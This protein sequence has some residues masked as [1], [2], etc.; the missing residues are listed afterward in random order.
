MKRAA[1]LV[2]FLPFLFFFAQLIPCNSFVC[3]GFVASA[4][5]M[6]SGKGHLLFGL[7]APMQNAQKVLDIVH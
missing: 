5:E 7:G 1:C 2:P 6:R 3:S 4:H